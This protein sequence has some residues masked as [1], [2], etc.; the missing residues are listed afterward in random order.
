MPSIEKRAVLT[1]VPTK[2]EFEVDFLLLIHVFGLEL[3]FAEFVS[4]IP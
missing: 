2:T 4:C 3:L 1:S